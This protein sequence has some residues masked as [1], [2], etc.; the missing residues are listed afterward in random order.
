MRKKKC[1]IM[2]EKKKD[3]IALTDFLWL[4]S[5]KTKER[6]INSSY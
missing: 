6:K 3:K 4:T 2:R 5:T 1:K